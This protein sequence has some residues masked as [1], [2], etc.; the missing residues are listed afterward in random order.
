MK[1]VRK[2]R[3]EHKKNKEQLE[4]PE[5]DCPALQVLGKQNCTED[6]CQFSTN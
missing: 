2:K 1:S 6:L 3:T 4:Q 5:E